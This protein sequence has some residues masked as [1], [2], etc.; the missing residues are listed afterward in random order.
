MEVRVF[1]PDRLDNSGVMQQV[2]E[3]PFLY[4]TFVEDVVVLDSARS[5]LNSTVT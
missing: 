3:I 1:D 2:A 5:R 4:M